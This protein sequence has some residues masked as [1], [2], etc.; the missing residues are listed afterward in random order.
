MK[1]KELQFLEDF[2]T[3][4]GHSVMFYKNWILNDNASRTWKWISNV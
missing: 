3:K 2:V 1:E 4:R